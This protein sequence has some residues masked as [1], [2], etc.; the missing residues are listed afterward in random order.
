[1]SGADRQRDFYRRRKA[2]RAI[3]ALEGDA[4]GVAEVVIA[5]GF[6]ARGQED[7]H[8]NVEAA[9]ERLL[10]LMVADHRRHAEFSAP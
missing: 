4:V 3:F 2:G 7:D 1:V 6:L 10:D 5:T 9:L 8:A